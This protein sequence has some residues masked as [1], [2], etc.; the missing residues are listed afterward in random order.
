MK[1]TAS[2]FYSSKLKFFKILDYL[3]L[4]FGVLILS[5]IMLVI[6]I[7][8]INKTKN[9]K[10]ILT[11]ATNVR[12]D[13]NKNDITIGSLVKAYPVLNSDNYIIKKNNKE[14]KNEEKE[15]FVANDTNNFDASAVDAI[16]NIIT[17]DKDNYTKK[18][19][20]NYDRIDIYGVTVYDYSSKKIDFKELFN[21]NINLTKKSDPILIYCTHTSETYKNSENYVFKYSGNYR[22][23][24]AKYNM[25]SVASIISKT[26]IEKGLNVVFDTT[27][28]DY[29]SYDNSYTNS[30]RTIEKNIQKYSRFGMTI[31]VHRDAAADLSF[32]PKTKING[33]NVAQLMVV[34]GVGYEG[35]PNKNW[36]EN[37]SLALHIVKLGEE[38]YPGLFRHILVRDA[39]YN[40]H[41]SPGSILVEVGA[42]GNTLE[43]AYY[44]ARCFANILAKLYK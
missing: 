4:S 23:K 22:S 26:L 16:S 10:A 31:D 35:Y 28:H 3:G 41:I 32:A 2:F 44:G 13:D 24:N 17:I 36:E 12:V 5:F 29:T 38:M 39:R 30:L 40:Q 15:N 9:V 18:S 1:K 34:I 33:K 21:R 27:A 11:L 7:Y 42:T 8:Y 19:T 20:K 43:E 37:L 6:G 14:E 25:L